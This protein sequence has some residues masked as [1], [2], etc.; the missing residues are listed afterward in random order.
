MAQ[1]HRRADDDKLALARA[2]FPDSAARMAEPQNF[3]DYLRREAGK[4]RVLTAGF[5]ARGL[6]A[7]L[8]WGIDAL[9]TMSAAVAMVVAGAR[10][11]LLQSLPHLVS[12]D[13]RVAES[14]WRRLE[15]WP[16]WRE[17]NCHR[18]QWPHVTGCS[19]ARPDA[20]PPVWSCCGVY[21]KKARQ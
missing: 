17:R 5:T 8:S 11:A 7:W 15:S 18:A 16:A 12:H 1:H 9:L 13:A 2:A 6:V 19:T 10:L 4:G 21:R 20:A 14:R 3:V